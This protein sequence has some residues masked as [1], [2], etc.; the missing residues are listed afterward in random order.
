M[1]ISNY[2]ILFSMFSKRNIVKIDLL[3][4][5]RLELGFYD[6]LSRRTS[7]IIKLSDIKSNSLNTAGAHI[8]FRLKNR[9]L[10]FVLSKNGKIR[11][12]LI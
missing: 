3:P 2:I 4:N 10:V 5:G 8:S 11:F 9:Y 7:E 1:I 12:V 6:V